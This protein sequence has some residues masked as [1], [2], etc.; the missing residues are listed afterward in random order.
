VVAPSKS[1]AAQDIAGHC[2]GARVL[3]PVPAGT[4]ARWV[5]LHN[6]RAALAH[7]ARAVMTTYSAA[8]TLTGVSVRIDP[9]GLPT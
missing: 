2:N 6:D 3:G 9:L 8:K 1:N 4:A 7:A 5:V